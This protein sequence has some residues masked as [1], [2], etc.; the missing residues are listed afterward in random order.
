[1]K[2]WLIFGCFMGFAFLG[3]AQPDSLLYPEARD[4]LVKKEKVKKNWIPFSAGA[5]WADGLTNYF[6]GYNYNNLR[7]NVQVGTLGFPIHNDWGSYTLFANQ[8][9]YYEIGGFFQL[10]DTNLNLRL[11]FTASYAETRDTM[12]YQSA[13]SV[14]SLVFRRVGMESARMISVG[15]AMMKTSRNYGRFF[16]MYAGGMA[17]VFGATGSSIDYLESAYDIHTQQEVSRNDFVFN[18]KPRLNLYGSA[19]LGVELTFFE[20]LGVTAEVHSGIG[21]Q[22]KVGEKPAGI[23]KVLYLVG[24]Q[25]YLVPN[26]GN[27]R[28][29][30]PVPLEPKEERYRKPPEKRKDLEEEGASEEE[31]E[32]EK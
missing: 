30:D 16:R 24:A 25:Y 11:R 3:L 10:A 5:F 29:K 27:L 17:E 12:F 8:P 14:D 13:F 32:P 6:D 21:A 2:R 9:Q 31:K 20:R 7:S 19:V 22:I 1:M 23:S 15:A 26:R 18:G 28:K 4:S